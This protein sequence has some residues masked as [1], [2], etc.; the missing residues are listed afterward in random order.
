M[1][2]KLYK[3][4]RKVR[5]SLQ[6]CSI[7]CVVLL[8]A[9]TIDTPYKQT[10]SYALFAFGVVFVV[11]VIIRIALSPF[12]KSDEEEDF[13]K[14]VEYVLEQQK[15]HNKQTTNKDTILAEY[16]PLCNL[17]AVQE[18]KIKELLSKLPSSSSKHDAINL[19]CISHYLTAMEQM[20]IID[21]KDKHNLKLWVAQVTGKKVPNSSQFNEAIPSKTVNKIAVARKELKKILN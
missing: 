9:A 5:T 17:S 7:I 21:L 6:V 2:D 12:V 15:T 20:E 11:L 14:K 13:E 4:D 1:N 8:I 3:F 16:S 19:A 18:E 10:L